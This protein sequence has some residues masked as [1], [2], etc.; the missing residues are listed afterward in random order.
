MSATLLGRQT[1]CAF[2]QAAHENAVVVH[3]LENYRSVIAF[4]KAQRDCYIKEE[5]KLV[6]LA[7]LVGHS[8]EGR[9]LESDK[10]RRLL[11]SATIISFVC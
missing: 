7:M 9:G 10:G 4:L 1:R 5:T 3:E 6:R 2:L 8:V 11:T